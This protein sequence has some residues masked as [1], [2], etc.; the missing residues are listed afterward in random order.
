MLRPPYPSKIFKL[1]KKYFPHLQRNTS[2]TW[3]SCKWFRVET[4]THGF[5]HFF[6][7]TSDRAFGYHSCLLESIGSNCN[8]LFTEE[9]FTVDFWMRFR[10]QPQLSDLQLALNYV[11][12]ENQITLTTTSYSTLSRLRCPCRKLHLSRFLTRQEN[13]TSVQLRLLSI[14]SIDKFNY[15]QEQVTH[16]IINAVFPE[17]SVDISGSQSSMQL[18]SNQLLFFRD[19]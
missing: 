5:T 11:S 14:E 9:T 2:P 7:S 16:K 1:C 4:C 18:S 12:T 15:D 8:F 17:F 19:V 10:Y 6:H 3:S 13:R